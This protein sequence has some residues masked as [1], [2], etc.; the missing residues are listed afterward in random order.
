MA[1]LVTVFCAKDLSCYYEEDDMKGTCLKSA[2]NS[3]GAKCSWNVGCTNDAYC[4]TVANKKYGVC[5]AN[6]AGGQACNGPSS[7]KCQEGFK[8][9]DKT[10]VCVEYRADKN[11]H[12]NAKVKCKEGL[13]CKA[14][15]MSTWTVC[16]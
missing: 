14:E 3:I 4:H 7:I 11:E 15:N 8:C 5:K 16:Q 2:K 6:V 13:V 9:D 12:C 10:S 1:P